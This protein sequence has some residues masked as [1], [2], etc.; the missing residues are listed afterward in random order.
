[1]PA[2]VKNNKNLWVWLGQFKQGEI[3]PSDV[4]KDVQDVAKD[5]KKKDV[6]RFR[7]NQTQGTTN[8]KRSFEQT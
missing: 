4:S 1:M 5:M 7:I 2:L 8:E 6:E 3:K